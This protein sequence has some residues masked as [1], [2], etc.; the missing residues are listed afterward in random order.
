MPY[1]NHFLNTGWIPTGFW[2]L[3]SSIKFLQTSIVK[4]MLGSSFYRQHSAI[5]HPPQTAVKYKWLI[6]APTDVIQFSWVTNEWWGWGKYESKRWICGLPQNYL[7]QI[8]IVS[9][10]L[11]QA[12]NPHLGSKIWG[13]NKEFEWKKT[14]GWCHCAAVPNMF[15]SWGSLVARIRFHDGFLK[16]SLELISLY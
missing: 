10:A 3:S 2:K 15:P 7:C 8:V 12:H 1:I 6:V 4:N 11:I 16:Q 13:G 5:L 14:K 9:Q